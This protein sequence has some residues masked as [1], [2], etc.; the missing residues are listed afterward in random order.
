MDGEDFNSFYQRTASGMLARAIM[1][2]GHEQDAQDAVNEAYLE[3]FRA[4][5][6]VRGYE[7]PEGW[8]HRVMVQRIWRIMGTN[9]KRRRLADRIMTP[10]QHSLD[11]IIMVRE[12]MRLLNEL[13][14]EERGCLIMSCQGLSHEEIAEQLGIKQSV[15]GSNIRRARRDLKRALGLEA[16]L[17]AFAELSATSGFGSASAFG[18][19]QVTALLLGAEFALERAIQV[20]SWA[21]TK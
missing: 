8:V 20:P 4:W 3:L 16:P 21:D 6:R 5:E 17:A 7:C 2:C 1:L 11:Q 15:V 9:D 19:D 10:R 18:G 13:P 12:V 14:R